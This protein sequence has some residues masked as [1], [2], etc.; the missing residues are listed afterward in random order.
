MAIIALIQRLHAAL[1]ESDP[2][3][4]NPFAQRVRHQFYEV[5]EEESGHTIQTARSLEDYQ[6]DYEAR[7]DIVICA[8]LPESG[9]LAP[10]FMRLREIQDAFPG[11]PVIVW[12]SREEASIQGTVLEDYGAAHYYTGNP[13]DAAEDFADLIL[14]YLEK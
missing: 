6:R 1:N 13:L 11:V 9:N 8:P 5:L 12:S 3:Q 4:L 10:G 2:N 7:P 14:K